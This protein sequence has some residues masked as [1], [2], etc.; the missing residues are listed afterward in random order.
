MQTSSALRIAR[1]LMNQ[2]GLR[3]WTVGLDRAKARAG[4][5]H[6]G[7]RRIT[8]S[9]PL[10]RLHDE[11]HVRDTI[12]HE[13]A[14]ALVGPEHGHDAV[15]KSMARKVGASDARC[16]SSEAA[17][18]LAPFVGVCAAGH[19]VRRHK[20]PTRVFSCPQCSP[21]FDPAHI[22]EWTYRGHGFTHHPSYSR[23]LAAQQSPAG[24]PT[25]PPV[26][27]LALGQLARITAEGRYQGA[28]GEIE[29]V[30]RTRYQVR[31]PEGVLSVPFGLVEPA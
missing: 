22:F 9:G 18:Q 11:E 15:W 30:G 21:R 20:R 26:Q 27:L 25:P 14:H 13:I 28:T 2:H 1:E 5:T 4:A 19:E 23:E 7:R 17:R 12:L 8:L 6:F 10:T 24:A 16:F 3:D 29:S 31:V